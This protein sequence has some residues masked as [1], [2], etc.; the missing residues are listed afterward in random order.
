[1]IFRSVKFC[2]ICLLFLMNG[3]IFTPAHA[4]QEYTDGE[5]T[6][7][8]QDYIKDFV[9]IPEGAIDWKVLGS[10]QEKIIRGMDQ[11]GL[12]FEYV[13]PVFSDEVKALDKQPI[14]IKGFMFPLEDAKNQSLFLFGPFPI[15]CPFHYHV[16]P[17]LV[18]EV[19]TAKRQEVPFSYDPIVLEGTLEL[20]YDDKETGV[21]YRLKQARQIKG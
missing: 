7:T 15:G 20:V 3:V 10:T 14:K 4:I 18:L 5:R 21:F 1:M 12:E 11:D 9:D 2:L 8:I 19:H 16:G 13:L 17:N 6:L